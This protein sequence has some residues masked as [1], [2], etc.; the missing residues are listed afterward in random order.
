MSGDL[1]AHVEIDLLVGGVKISVRQQQRVAEVCI[2][3]NVLSSRRETNVPI[4]ET[5]TAAMIP[6]D[7]GEPSIRRNAER[8]RAHQRRVGADRNVGNKG[9]MAGCSALLAN[10]CCTTASV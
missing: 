7:P 9:L 10:D 8:P 4:A 2:T 6:L 3:R 1:I 5:N